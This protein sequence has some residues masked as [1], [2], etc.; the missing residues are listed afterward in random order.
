MATVAEQGEGT[1]HSEQFVLVDGYNRLEAEL[2]DAEIY[3]ATEADRLC[4]S[5][6]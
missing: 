3:L 2:P 1:S 5:A 4:V 6:T